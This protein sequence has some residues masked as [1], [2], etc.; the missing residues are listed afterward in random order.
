MNRNPLVSIVLPVY[1]GAD[2]VSRSIESVLKQTYENLELIIVNDCSTD[3]SRDVVLSFVDQD[4]RIKLIDHEVNKKL[5]AALNTGF[6]NA[7]GEL[8][9]WT[10]H[11][12][13]FLP[14]ALKAMTSFMLDNPDTGLV[15]ANEEIADE[16]SGEIKAQ[17]KNQIDKIVFGNVIGACFLYRKNVMEQ[18]GDYDESLF[19]AE[20]YDY[21]LRV[22]KEFRCSHLQET[23]YRYSVSGDSLTATQ[24]PG[25]VKATLKAI[26]KNLI[27]YDGRKSVQ[28][29]EILIRW[30]KYW[31]KFSFKKG[32]I[33]FK[34]FVSLFS[35]LLF[36]YPGFLVLHT[37][38]KR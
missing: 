35:R 6:R 1:N 9:T 22:W 7:K 21:W 32:N 8:L 17:T 38:G 5:P 28:E 14:N 11:D 24:K 20:D 36:K 34:A 26:R 33:N 10:S 25:I 30:L 16:S 29:K 31:Y 23:L 3:N 19:L 27:P 37:L 18:V 4:D 2:H 15:F 13:E 12:N